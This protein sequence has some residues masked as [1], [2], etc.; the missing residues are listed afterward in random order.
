MNIFSLETDVAQKEILV[1]AV[2]G[3]MSQTICLKI[4]SPHLLHALLE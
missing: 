4:Q 3:V 2:E 1:G